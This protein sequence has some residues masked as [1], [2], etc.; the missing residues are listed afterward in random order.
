MKKA[1]DG[2][3]TTP[4]KRSGRPR[5]SSTREDRILVRKY[6]NNRRSSSKALSREL[7]ESTGCNISAR[8]VRRRL[9]N[10]GLK[11]CRPAKKPFINETQRKR[12]L[13]W[14][15]EFQNWTVDQWKQVIFSDESNLSVFSYKG[16][17]RRRAGERYKPNCMQPTVKHPESVMI[18]SCISHHGVGRLFFLE[19]GSR[20]NAELYLQI[21]L[22]KLLPSAA[23]WFPND[24]YFFQDDGAP[25]YRAKSVKKFIVD[26]GIT[27]LPWWPGQS[28]DLNVIENLWHRVQVLVTEQKPTTR[29]DLTAAII[30]VWHHV[31][32]LESLQQLVESMP[33]RIQ[34][35]IEAK[36]FPTKY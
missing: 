24:E 36:G 2:V 16:L 8:S 25:C 6:L 23:E 14:C 26:N 32:S 27:P 20:F 13:R 18:W 21:L 4:K 17:V 35:V 30:N 29:R 3:S 22:K 9:Y 33:R 1:A 34:A 10:V 12:Q 31:V 5:S 19:K 28:P 11:S 7:Q 15:R